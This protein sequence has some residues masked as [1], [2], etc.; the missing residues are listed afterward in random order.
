MTARQ[1]FLK[2]TYPLLMFLHRKAKPANNE[3]KLLP[4]ESLFDL[5]VELNNGELLKFDSLRGKKIMIVNTASDCGYTAQYA[6]LQ[7]L[8]KNN[9]GQLMVIGFPANDFKE[10]EKGSDEDIAEFC[11]SNFGIAFPLSKKTTVVKGS[12]QH[13]VFQ[14]LTKRELNG[15]NDRQPSWNFCKYL[16]DER[17]ELISVFPPSVSPLSKEVLNRIGAPAVT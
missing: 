7:K 6:E 5:F 4:L 16:V 8:Y 10:Q 15:W 1:K 13:P 11:E 3:K 2:V 17:G 12:K 14:W 9:I